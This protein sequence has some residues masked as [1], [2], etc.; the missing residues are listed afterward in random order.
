M[1]KIVTW[2]DDDAI[3]NGPLRMRTT[4]LTQRNFT[5]PSLFICDIRLYIFN[6]WRIYGRI[7]IVFDMNVMPLEIA[8]N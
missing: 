7:F 2:D 5:K 4:N 6:S 8:A 1:L 3:T